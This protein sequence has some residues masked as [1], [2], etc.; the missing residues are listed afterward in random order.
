MGIVPKYTRQEIKQL[1]ARRIEFINR[2]I[3]LQLQ[4]LGEKCVNHAREIDKTI[5]FEDQ[6]GN[7]R[8]SIGYVIYLNGKPMG[9]NFEK[10]KGGDE[11][12]EKGRK[13]AKEVAGKYPRGFLLVVVAGMEYA[14]YVEA[15][16]R[17]V[18]TSAEH[19]AE[20]ELPGMLKQID[21]KIKRKYG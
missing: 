7:L 6:T 13:L 9:E 11:G 18:L 1:L 17:D 3:I 10:V 21:D 2:A 5:G 14:L 19:L 16:N 4:R 8:S 20:K 15:N 12:I